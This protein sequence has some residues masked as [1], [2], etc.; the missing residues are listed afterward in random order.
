MRVCLLCLTWDFAQGKKQLANV[1]VLQYVKIYDSIRSGINTT[2]KVCCKGCRWMEKKK[3][4][5]TNKRRQA[6]RQAGGRAG[7]HEGRQAG[8]QA[9]TTKSSRTKHNERFVALW[10]QLRLTRIEA[11]NRP[12]VRYRTLLSVVRPKWSLT[13][14]WSSRALLPRW[15]QVTQRTTGFTPVLYL[16]NWQISNATD[17]LSAMVITC[18]NSFRDK[19]FF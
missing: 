19:C 11:V 16:W 7:G 9:R 6:V 2:F 17:S 14:P 4:V 1:T 15:C 12:C 10:E 8:R 5:N 18:G 13:S 3:H